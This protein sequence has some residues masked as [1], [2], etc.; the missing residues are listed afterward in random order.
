MTILSTEQYSPKQQKCAERVLDSLDH[1]LERLDK[2]Y[3]SQR[4]HER[5]QL[6]SVAVVKIPI[7]DA[8]GEVH[9][10]K[11]YTHNISAGGMCFIYPDLIAAEKVFVG[12]ITSQAG[13]NLWFNSKIV[14]TKEIQ[15]EGFWEYGVAFLGRIEL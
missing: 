6:R 9:E 11:V 4:S 3:K 12:L 2:H 5:K 13:V 1:L 8:A 10:I 15:G 14:R 7:P